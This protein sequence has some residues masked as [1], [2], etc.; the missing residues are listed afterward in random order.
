MFGSCLEFG[1]LNRSFSLGAKG[2]D[3][4]VSTEEIWELLLGELFDISDVLV[5]KKGGS[6]VPIFYKRRGFYFS[7]V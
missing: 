7:L 1:G 5:A 4:E 6:D 3:V 2:R